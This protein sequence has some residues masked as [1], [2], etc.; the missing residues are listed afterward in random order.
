MRGRERK[1]E[2]GMP[3]V[4]VAETVQTLCAAKL[5]GRKMKK[6]TSALLPGCQAAEPFYRKSGGSL[7]NRQHPE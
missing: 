6:A 3:E 5:S 2:N 4:S 7:E 1:R